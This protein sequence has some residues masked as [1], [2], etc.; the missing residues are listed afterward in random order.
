MHQRSVKCSGFGLT[1]WVGFCFRCQSESVKPAHFP[2]TRA[3]QVA[4][5]VLVNW[6]V[7]IH[8]LCL[9]AEARPLRD[10]RKSLGAKGL[11]RFVI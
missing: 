4:G 9:N 5:L 11:T 2:R 1:G 8:K 6:A 10:W 3:S 7:G